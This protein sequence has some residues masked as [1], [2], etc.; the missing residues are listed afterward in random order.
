MRVDW[1]ALGEEGQLFV[2]PDCIT[3]D[4]Q[5]AMDEDF[6]DLMDQAHPDADDS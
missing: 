6:M 3:Q 1:E 4:E 2:C 5:Q